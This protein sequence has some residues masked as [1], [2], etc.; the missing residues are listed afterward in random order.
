MIEILLI[1]NS[2]CKLLEDLRLMFNFK[3]QLECCG[4]QLSVIGK[5][6]QQISYPSQLK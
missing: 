6:E 1:P 4:V 3:I 5:P 2:D